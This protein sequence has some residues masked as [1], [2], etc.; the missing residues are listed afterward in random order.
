MRPIS[1]VP[2][3][4]A[5][6]LTCLRLSCVLL[7]ALAWG[8]VR[9]AP[10]AGAASAAS[11]TAAPAAASGSAM[12]AELAD[13]ES[14]GRAHP[15]DTAAALRIRVGQ[16]AIGSADWVEALTLQGLLH[17]EASEFE[18]ATDCARRLQEQSTA[19]TDAAARLIRASMALKSGNAHEADKLLNAAAAE[20]PAATPATSR[21]RFL[22]AHSKARQRAGKLD[23]A[24]RLHLQEIDLADQ[25]GI[26]W[27]RAEA[28][29]RAAYSLYKAQQP[30]RARSTNAEALA[31]ATAAN[32]KISLARVHNIQGIL[33]DGPGE[34]AAELHSMQSA[35]NYAHE[36]GAK[37]DEALLLANM[38]DFFLQRGDYRTALRRAQ[39]AL[40]LTREVRDTSS[41]IIALWNMGLA[42][43]GLGDVPDG[44]R[45]VEL[46]LSMAEHR[47]D[48]PLVSDVLLE[49]GTALEKAGDA[50]GAV[51]ALHRHR[52]I[53]DKLV[54]R[55]Q[56]KAILELQ[57]EFDSDRR[58][59]ALA[60][61]NSD[62]AIKSTQLQRRDLQQRLWWLLAATFVLSFAVVLLMMRRVRRTNQALAHSNAQLKVQSERDPLTGLANRRYFQAAMKQMSV[63]GQLA[64]TVY[65]LDI[66][67]FKRI[68]DEHGHA[69]GDAVLVA[70]AQRLAD[71]LREPDLVVRWGG[72][73]FLVVVQSLSRE[74][75][76]ALAQRL[77]DAVGQAPVAWQ[78]REIT[79]TGS[80]GYASFPIEPTG[81]AVAWEPAI[82]L[83]DTALYLAK[84]HGRNRAYGVG[85]MHAQTVQGL[86]A[87]TA[88]L[89]SAWRDGQVTLTL[90]RGPMHEGRA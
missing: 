27:R 50:A 65:L 4:S 10:A 76:D 67:H 48:A 59:R 41:E 17:T 15:S 8:G 88:S 14:T 90:L 39:E 81:L 40:P 7:A 46:A 69:A 23:D 80:I 13:F 55:D 63:D 3:A 32:D 51:Q 9:A 77:L 31:I 60:L 44:K 52:A 34:V 36:A 74:Q 2:V 1:R 38:S 37:L 11:A 70:M 21:L 18:A 85:L 89:E 58:S 26:A 64:G 83:V 6:R 30:E 87:I 35:I 33:L 5:L 73:E 61:L 42:H 71:A 82:N 57:E 28:R 78:G 72:E 84:A 29:T 45:Y 79:V 53:A 62:N 49:F 16:L 66:D 47:G 19:T 20:L 24:V 68:N 75:V 22:A 25:L 12:A 43:I 86:Q 54:Q 56:Q